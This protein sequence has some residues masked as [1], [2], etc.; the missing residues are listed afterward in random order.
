MRKDELFPSKWIKTVEVGAAGLVLTIAAVK[1]EEFKKPDSD[2]KE[3]KPVA[4][5]AETKKGFPINK[6]NFDLIVDATGEEDTDDWV[7]KRIK[8]VVEEVEAFGKTTEGVRVEK[9][10]KVKVKK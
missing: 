3:V 5:F 4:F 9:A 8:L 1:K 7:G 2:V 6:T 10:P